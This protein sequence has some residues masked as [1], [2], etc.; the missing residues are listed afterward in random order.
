MMPKSLPQTLAGVL[1]LGALSGCAAMHGSQPRVAGNGS[2]AQPPTA[3]TVSAAA[4]TPAG[5][6][7]SQSLPLPVAGA[8]PVSDTDWQGL[9]VKGTAPV[10][11][12]WVRLSKGFKLP[13]GHKHE[14]RVQMQ[15]RL[16][17]GLHGYMKRAAL[18]AKPY[19]YYIAQQLAKR[20]MP[21]DLALLP[22]VESAYN[23][24]AYSSSRASGIWQFISSTGR[25]YGL[26]QNWWYSGRRDVAA[27]TNAAL[28]L[29]SDL[30]HRFNDN[31][32][33]A[34]AAYNSGGITVQNAIDR[35]R[36]RGEPTDFWHLHLPRQ[37]R[38]YVP[39]LLAVRD[40][41]ADPQKYGINLPF[42]ANAP[43]LARINLD[44]QIDLA[45][46]AKMAGLSVKQMYL[47]NPGYGRWA[48]PPDG[49]SDLFIPV[50]KKQEFLA[51]LGTMK[52][53]MLASWTRHQ[54]RR[55]ET[56]SGIAAHY[57]TSVAVLRHRN[58]I[59][60]NIIRVGHTLMI[61]SPSA[62]VTRYVPT[63]S[64]YVASEHSDYAPPE[65]RSYHSTTVHVHRG[66]T[67]SGIAQ[68]HHVSVAS[69]TR[70][71]H[72][73]KSTPLQVGQTLTVR[74]S[75]ASEHH[76]TGKQN[77]NPTIAR[78]KRGDTLWH[79]AHHYGVSVA[80]IADWNGISTH[81]TLRVGQRIKVWP[82]AHTRTGNSGHHHRIRYTVHN[83]DSLWSIADHF[84]VPLSK[85][86][87][88]NSMSLKSTLHP[89]E[90]LTLFV[91]NGG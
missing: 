64:D 45:V 11:D 89:G 72:M 33:L 70:W 12:L 48:T 34:L 57:G 1:V 87:D 71:N 56:L 31:W 35:N 82:S 19:L 17:S 74:G 37:T 79:L 30:Y 60:G 6:A 75:I 41:V 14:R 67:L 2:H 5:A 46:A 50:D 26:K 62:H 53:T 90:R 3:L 91:D 25:L 77:P 69:L 42:I 44:G 85:L 40:I 13:D 24:Y 8:T 18:R 61:P 43:Y 78:V 49:P 84:N 28:N 58:N 54:I 20:G 21:T 68:T 32:L 80:K 73:S 83:G 88:W 47:L 63:G 66:D 27:S 39:K 9:T 22:I 76:Y 81:A 52:K 65:P 16:Y 36:R 4:A 29:L 55:G 86:A 51:K 38:A 59:H 23:P 15:I 10:A 7:P